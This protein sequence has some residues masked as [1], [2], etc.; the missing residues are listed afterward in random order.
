VQDSLE[1]TMNVNNTMSELQGEI[2][3]LKSEAS[4]LR[5]EAGLKGLNDQEDHFRDLWDELDDLEYKLFQQQFIAN[6]E[7]LQKLVDEVARATANGEAVNQSLGKIK[8]AIS[9][10]R[11][12]L[13]G[14]GKYLD[15]AK[16]L[17]DK[18]DELARLVSGS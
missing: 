9:G 8:K 2:T 1:E 13:Q 3:A 4:R 14:A 18:L 12:K 16:A 5:T 11:T 15:D 10:L 6:N 17:S 7:K